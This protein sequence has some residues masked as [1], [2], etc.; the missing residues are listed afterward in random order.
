MAASSAAACILK[1]GYCTV[2][3][4]ELMGA[5]SHIIPNG[6]LHLP[7]SQSITFYF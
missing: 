1:L 5:L 7:E 6:P 3:Q 2:M 4:K